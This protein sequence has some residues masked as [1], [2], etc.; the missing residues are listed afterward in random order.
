MLTLL[1][2]ATL[3]STLLRSNQVEGEG[4][5]QKDETDAVK[6]KSE[7]DVKMEEHAPKVEEVKKEESV[8]PE[9]L[10]PEEFGLKGLAELRRAKWFSAMA[11]PLPSCVEAIKVM[12]DKARRDQVWGHLGDWAL[13][14]L[15][16]RSL[17]SAGFTMSPSKSIMRIMEVLAS[18]LLMPD[19]PGIKDP[20]EREEVDVFEK[21]SPQMKEDVTRQAQIDLRNIHYRKI[22]L[23]L[24]MERLLTRKEEMMAKM[25][26]KDDVK[27]EANA[28]AQKSEAKE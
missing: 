27:V 2:C 12:K 25:S 6:D 19:G 20:C 1:L 3:T 21:M 11:A 5:D 15:V 22:H 17:F 16:E 23:V 7:E 9:D 18:G 13:E 24:G 26:K 8:D 14:L 10:L 4:D 28:E